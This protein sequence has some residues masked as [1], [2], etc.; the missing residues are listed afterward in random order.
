MT[1]Q[2]GRNDDYILGDRAEQVGEFQWEVPLLASG[3][4]ENPA[5]V[6]GDYS[7]LSTGPGAEDRNSVRSFHYS[8]R[9]SKGMGRKIYF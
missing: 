6:Q 2:D 4:G 9:R 1:D 5:G 3:E 8:S 7:N